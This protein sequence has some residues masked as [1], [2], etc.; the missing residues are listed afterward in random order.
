MP[1]FSCGIAYPP[2][3]NAPKPTPGQ[4]QALYG[5]FPWQVALL[6]N[7]LTYIGGAVL[8]NHKVVLTVAHKVSGVS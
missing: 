8:I 5:A 7:D 6:T 4:G 3:S 1:Y 2:V